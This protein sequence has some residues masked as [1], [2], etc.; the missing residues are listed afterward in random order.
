[1]YVYIYIYIY[2]YVC[3]HTH[4]HTYIYIYIC[5]YTHTHTH[6]QYGS[7]KPQ[8]KRT[9]QEAQIYL[10]TTLPYNELLHYYVI[11]TDIVGLNTCV[12]Q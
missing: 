1:M 3:I 4:T 2:M 5:M 9:Y 12:M 8:E 7:I 11:I 6:I 10:R